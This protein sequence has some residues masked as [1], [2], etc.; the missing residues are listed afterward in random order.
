M[1]GHQRSHTL[2]FRVDNRAQEACRARAALRGTV[3]S[4]ASAVA[5]FGLARVPWRWSLLRAWR[6][7]IT[8]T[9]NP[10]AYSAQES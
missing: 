1:A 6:A 9:G 8:A 7:L 3:A 5:A 10:A 2:L 4:S